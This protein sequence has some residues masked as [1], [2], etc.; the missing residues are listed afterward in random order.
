MYISSVASKH[1]TSGASTQS[2]TNLCSP[3]TGVTIFTI[4]VESSRVAQK[5]SKFCGNLFDAAVERSDWETNYMRYSLGFRV[6]AVI[7]A[8]DNILRCYVPMDNQRPQLDLKFYKD[9]C[10]DQNGVSLR[11]FMTTVYLTHHFEVPV[12]VVFTKY[13]Q[14]LC[15][16]AM[17]VF[18]Y[19]SEYPDS[20]ASEV[21]EERF[22]EHYLR[23][24]GN[25]IKFVRLKSW[26]QSQMPRVYADFLWQKC[27]CKLV[28]VMIL[29]R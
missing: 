19:P 11:T 23:P 8:D 20:D 17:D 28:A 1:R 5:N 26:V 27:T 13:D 3:I 16:V 25:D 29:L 2:T 7:K 21:A 22:Q 10:P 6:F 15:N 9:I 12:I 4:P 14:F 24:L 18:D